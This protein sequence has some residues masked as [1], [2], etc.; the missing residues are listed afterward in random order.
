MTSSSRSKC[1]PSYQSRSSRGCN[2]IIMSNYES[3]KSCSWDV[4]TS[5]FT[6]RHSIFR[7]C[8][9]SCTHIQTL[10]LFMHSYSDIVFIH[11]FIFRHCIYSCIQYSDIVFIHAFIFI[12]NHS[13]FIFIFNH[14]IFLIYTF[15][16]KSITAENIM[17][18]KLKFLTRGS[19]YGEAAELLIQHNFKSFPIVDSESEFPT[20]VV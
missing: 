12:F 20:E 11:A 2:G 3:F 8:I 6:F 7:H 14:S 15:R 13:I 10:Y 19:T 9:Y 5:D 4:L 16:D 1:S 18:R 17:E